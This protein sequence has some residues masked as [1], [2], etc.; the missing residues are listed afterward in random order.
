MKR[1][2]ICFMICKCGYNTENKKSWSNH[3]RYG[4]PNDIKVSDK[5]CKF[6]KKNMPKKKPSEEGFFCNNKCYGRWRS[7]NMTLENAPN[8]KTGES[9]TRIYSI[10]LGMKYRCSNKKSGD[11]HNYGGRGISVC[12]EWA[13][14][15]LE[16][17]K[18]ANS[19]GYNDT[20]TIER[21]NVN[22]NYCPENCT[23]IPHNEQYKNRRNVR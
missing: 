10:W 19:N 17:K 21:I 12:S 8:I 16:F 13:D 2:I 4:C 23:W 20:L 6:C 3:V 11:F 1:E 9:R 22:G 15:F 18:W 14:S 5:E 7:E